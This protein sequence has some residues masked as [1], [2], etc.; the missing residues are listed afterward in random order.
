MSIVKRSGTRKAFLGAVLMLATAQAS[1]NC[2]DL[3]GQSG[4]P[5]SA[6]FGSAGTEVVSEILRLDPKLVQGVT[7]P[8]P[9]DFAGLK[10]LREKAAV[11]K[12]RR[13]EIEAELKTAAESL[14]ECLAKT[15]AL[16]GDLS[17]AP[18]KRTFAPTEQE[19]KTSYRKELGRLNGELPRGLRIVGQRIGADERRFTMIKQAEALAKESALRFAKLFPTTG[20]GSKEAYLAALRSSPSESVRKALKA[21]EGN[22]IRPVVFRTEKRREWI[23]KTGFQNQYVTGTSGGAL[24]F[25]VRKR[26]EASLLGVDTLEQFTALDLEVMPKY[27]TLKPALESGLKNQAPDDSADFSGDYGSDS[28][29]FKLS[30][31]ENRMTWT[32]GDSLNNSGVGDGLRPPA[33]WDDFF[34]PWNQRELMVPFMDFGFENGYES[35]SWPMKGNGF[36]IKTKYTRDFYWE[37]QIYGPLRLKDVEIFE[38]RQNPPAGEFLRELLRSKITIR[39]ARTQPATLWKPTAEELRAAGIR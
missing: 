26:T 7:T 14:K 36:E 34:I 29:W 10:S 8:K 25:D 35:F 27:A 20:Y 4:Q 30:S 18:E 22:H 37:V 9:E 3:P 39:D 6:A 13:P 21:I 17:S 5:L 23:A 32:P 38:F 15:S 33:T 31:V 11:A 19:L 16:Y 1:A 12:L 24:G 28:Y 2:L